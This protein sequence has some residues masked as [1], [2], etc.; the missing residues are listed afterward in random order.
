MQVC[1]VNVASMPNATLPDLEILKA[2][3]DFLQKDLREPFFL[4]VGFH[5]PH[6]P[7]KFPKQ[8][9]STHFIALNH[10]FS[11]LNKGWLYVFQSITR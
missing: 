10:S 8:Y 5:K 1:P 6:I 11:N 7:L 4:A 9:L 2:A 3:K